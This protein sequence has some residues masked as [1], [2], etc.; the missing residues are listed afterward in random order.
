MK[1]ISVVT[2]CFN[3]EDTISK[4]YEAL[5]RIFNQYSSKYEFEVIF[6]DD[7][8]T[9]FTQDELRKLAEEDSRVKVIINS[10]NFGR[11][12]S[13]YYGIMQ[14]AGDAVV[15]IAPNLQDPPEL[16]LDFIENWEQGCEVVAARK[17][18]KREFSFLNLLRKFYYFSLELLKDEGSTLI[19]NYTGFGLY[20][21]KVINKLKKV[22][23]PYPYFRGAVLDMGT[24]GG[25]PGIPLALATDRCFTLLDSVGKKVKAVS[26]FIDVLGL[27]Q[28]CSATQERVEAFGASHSV[29][30]AVVTA[31]AMAS[32][33]VLVEYAAPILIPGGHLIVSKGNPENDEII[34]GDIA[35]KFCGLSRIETSEFDLPRGLG[36]RTFLIYKKTSKPSIKLPRAVGVARKTPLA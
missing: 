35:A 32:L 3:N 7:S 24:G 18:D 14:A 1:K 6:V 5:C 16:I 29:R 8:S 23:D 26:S 36:H 2:S 12:K 19:R 30:F 28:R 21:K 13:S 27:S 34:S 15:Y 25:F 11:I 10:R 17:C 22:N 31:R 20:D 33:P 9:D 4:L